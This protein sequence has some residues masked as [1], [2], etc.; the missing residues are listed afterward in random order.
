VFVC[1]YKVVSMCVSKF[2]IVFVVYV[3]V[4]IKSSKSVIQQ[5]VAT[6]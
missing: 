1:L 4:W 6:L 2:T 3:S 5:I